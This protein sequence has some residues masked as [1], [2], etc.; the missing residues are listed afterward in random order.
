MLGFYIAVTTRGQGQSP[1][2]DFSSCTIS[3][4]HMQKQAVPLNGGFSFPKRNPPSGIEVEDWTTGLDPAKKRKRSRST[5]E[6]LFPA[7]MLDQMSLESA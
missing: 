2:D 3:C 6:C 7:E 4:N 1:M 5:G